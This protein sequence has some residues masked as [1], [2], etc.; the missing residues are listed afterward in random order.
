MVTMYAIA[1]GG[2]IPRAGLA[3][4]DISCAADT[5]RKEGGGLPRTDTTMPYEEDKS[6]IK[7]NQE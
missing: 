3:H 2:K 5:L 7:L 6:V 4:C 1:R